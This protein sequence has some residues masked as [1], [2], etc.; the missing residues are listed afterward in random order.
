MLGHMQSFKKR[1]R[2]T[3]EPSARVPRTFPFNMGTT[4]AHISP[5]VPEVVISSEHTNT[6]KQM[7]L[8]EVLRGFGQPSLQG[9]ESSALAV[10]RAVPPVRETRKEKKSRVITHDTEATVSN[11]VVLCLRDIAQQELAFLQKSLTFYPPQIFDKN[12]PTEPII[13][14]KI[15]AEYLTIPRMLGWKYYPSA[16]DALSSGEALA[17]QVSFTA[18][19]R[20]L[21]QEVS[22]AALL[23][24][25]KKPYG[26]ILTLPCGF[27]KT[28]IGLFIAHSLGLRTLIVVH[29]EFLLAQWKE[30]IESFLP[31]ASVGRLQGKKEEID[32]DFVIAMVQTI[33]TREYLIEFFDGFGTLILDE[34]HHFAAAMFS[35]VFFN[36]RIR[37][38][39]GLSATPK[40]K[41]GLTQLLHDY[42]GEFGA[43]IEEGTSATAR[44]C[45]IFRIRFESSRRRTD[46]M[47]PAAVQKLKG[48]LVKDE[49]RNL[50]I[51]DL[52]DELVN[53]GRKIIVL[54]S[55]VLG[56]SKICRKNS[57]GR[58]RNTHAR[59][60]L[61]R[62]RQ[63]TDLQLRG[64]K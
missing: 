50:L 56:T 30:R 34:A 51:L 8:D 17:E 36:N 53:A 38:V 59:S 39:L 61:V 7:T 63:K 37:H 5:T 48:K 22:D 41:D 47:T 13:A 42:L 1:R 46:E 54:L 15:D 24:I 33:A 19:L 44:S 35:R 9:S 11:G 31:G 49:K 55:N 21:Q 32:R 14:Y 43:H 58:L 3:D 25:R 12:A 4:G 6:P 26:T 45:K 23:K 29:K 64:P 27:G 28:V 10:S 20:P 40:R 62:Q 52:V 16:V 2:D 18:D 57:H 60:T